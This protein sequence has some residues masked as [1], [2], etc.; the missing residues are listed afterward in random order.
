MD[1]KLNACVLVV[2][3]PSLPKGT[4][5]WWRQFGAVIAPRALKEEITNRKLDF[6]DLESL[7]LPGSVYDA[8]DLVRKLSL[9]TDATG[10]RVSKLVNFN[11]FELWW[12]H[13]NDLMHKFCLPYTQYHVLLKHLLSYRRA[14]LYQPPF[15]A[16]FRLFL[17]AHKFRYDMA[18]KFSS[19]FPALGV[20]CQAALSFVFLPWLMV[21]RARLLLWT[22]D[23]FD[24]QTDYDFRM[25]YIYKELRGRGIRFVEFIR[26]LEPTRTLL[27]HALV[28]KRPVFYS[29][30]VTGVV[31]FL[32]HAI[33]G[34]RSFGIPQKLSDEERFWFSV[35]TY[36]LGNVR[37]SEMSIVFLKLVLRLIGVRA[38]IIDAS[39]SRTL[40]EIIACKLLGIP[41]VGIQHGGSLR[42]YNVS[43]YMPEFDGEKSLG[44][45][46]YGVWSKWW[47]EYHLKHSAIYNQDTLHVAGPMHPL[48]RRLVAQVRNEKTGKIKVLF[49]SEELAAPNEVIPYLEGL[50][51]D[52]EVLVYVKFRYY[53]DGFE[54]WLAGNRPDLLSR[55]AQEN[56]LRGSMDEA[57]ALTDIA[58]GCRSNGVIEALLQLKP[59]VY[60]QTEKWK[61][62]FE[63]KSFD[64]PYRFF[65]E[66]VP[67]LLALVRV[68]REVPKEVLE[69][70][71]GRFFGA[72]GHN[73]SKWA[74]DEAE[75]FL[76]TN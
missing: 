27:L 54:E 49:V 15:P 62:Y 32:S 25:A 58:V 60:F 70:L 61:D 5:A 30:A 64:S 66:D 8:S 18:D 2:F 21:R 14:Y 38:A 33:F 76:K 44:V 69:E 57:I 19:T 3:T 47:M 55:L 29:H 13:Y 48:D 68:N 6:V 63:L 17:D 71:R 34:Q 40:H 59:F 36:Y 73:G 28:R 31:H 65:A 35:A 11:G 42:Q 67:D 46:R 20:W 39:S 10:R 41:V 75:K 52:G 53:K 72:V 1:K 16:L 26:S 12:I 45:D 50:L 23:Q 24:K 4:E 51:E 9:A 74:V 37:G 43:D 22:S 7:M 56:I